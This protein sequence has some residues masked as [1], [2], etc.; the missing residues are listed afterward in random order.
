ML[1]PLKRDA[2]SG[3]ITEYLDPVAPPTLSSVPSKSWLPVELGLRNTPVIG[4]H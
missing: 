1:G 3:A 2:L 4:S